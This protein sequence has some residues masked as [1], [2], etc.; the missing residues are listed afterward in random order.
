[1][2]SEVF[3]FSPEIGLNLPEGT[4]YGL[5]VHCVELETQRNQ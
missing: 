5:P 4:Q 1:M 3:R 2:M